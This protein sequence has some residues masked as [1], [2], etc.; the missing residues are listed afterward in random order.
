MNIGIF[1][2][3]FDPVHVGH[4]IL[5]SYIAEY[6]DT[7]EVWFLVSPQSPFKSENELSGEQLRFE[8]TE[9]ALRKYEKLKASDFEFT[10]TKPSYTINTLRALK[11]KYPDNNFSLIIGADNWQLFEGWKEH[12]KILEDFALKVYPRPGSRIVIP[13][14]LRQKVEALDSPMIGISS[15]FIRE[16]IRE[17]QNMR[18]FLS[19]EVYEYIMAKGLYK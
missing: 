11:E 1:S 13:N 18:A 19:D 10:M 16:G 14:K 2:G 6:T 15:T 9:L 3:T 8:M 7:D 12:D 4:V 17:G 5:A